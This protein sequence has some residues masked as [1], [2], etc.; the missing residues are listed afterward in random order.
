MTTKPPRSRVL[1]VKPCPAALQVELDLPPPLKL[2]LLN[3]HDAITQQGKLP[4]AP[5]DP[6][7]DQVLSQYLAQCS[8]SADQQHEV[9]STGLHVSHQHAL[10]LWG[11]L[12]QGR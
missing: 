3:D 1:Q 7:V 11:R 12:L 4:P 5:R 10:C 9:R 2:V 6:C 8:G